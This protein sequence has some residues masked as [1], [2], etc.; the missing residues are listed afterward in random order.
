MPHPLGLLA[1]PLAFLAPPTQSISTMEEVELVSVKTTGENGVLSLDEA[2]D[3][4]SES[5]LIGR[6][7]ETDKGGGFSVKVKSLLK[8][9]KTAE[10]RDTHGG[11][12]KRELTYISG[13]AY[14][15]GSTIGSGIFITPSTIL[16]RTGSF[17]LSM[18]M[19]VIGG[20]I[21]IA[22]SFCYI[23]LA[24]LIRQSGS[25]FSYIKE[26]YSF[27]KRNKVVEVLGS[28]LAF[29]FVWGTVFVIRTS[30]LAIIT[31][32]CAEYFIK[33]LFI[34]CEDIPTNAVKLL[35]I[36]VLST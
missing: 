7:C 16:C 19:W 15:I 25:D 35:S 2:S 17:G 11:G 13:V 36:S 32:A 20:V 28:L 18:V 5:D 21:A 34:E 29:L 9:K 4:D 24:L 6:S 1:P 27:N 23:E 12:L 26:T 33:P 22:G 3:V 14:I 30:S 10:D 8:S 31:L